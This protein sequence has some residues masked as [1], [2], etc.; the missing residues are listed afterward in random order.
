ML[1]R[2][3]QL[4]YVT[5]QQRLRSRVGSLAY[6]TRNIS[7]GRQLWAERKRGIAIAGGVATTF[8]IAAWWY[9]SRSGSLK[10]LDRVKF[11]PTVVQELETIGPDSKLIRVRLPPELFPENAS[12]TFRP[13][14]ALNFKNSDI[15]VERAYTP[16]EGISADGEMKFWIKKYDH[17]E[18]GRWLHERQ[19]GETLEVRGPERSWDGILDDYDHIVMVCATNVNTS[20][21]SYFCES[22]RL[23]GGRALLLFINFFTPFSPMRVRNRNRPEFHDLLCFIHTATIKLFRLILS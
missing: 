9:H 21:C 8:S 6:S 17:G 4:T 11:V 10:K 15:Q 19:Q 18:T 23:L 5:L 12:N 22:G 1:L 16:L 14:W 7:N 20:T 2:S 3:G 13:I